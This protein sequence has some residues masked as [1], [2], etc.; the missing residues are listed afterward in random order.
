MFEKIG[1]IRFEMM[2]LRVEVGDA[3]YY[4]S[5]ADVEKVGREEVPLKGINGDTIYAAGI[6]WP[7]KSG[8]ALN[9]KVNG[10]IFVSPMRAIIRLISG[11]VRAAPL[12]YPLDDAPATRRYSTEMTKGLEAGF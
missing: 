12:S 6:A 10:G 3:T 2:A 8:K 7:S 1:R 9:V 5:A 4:V 11:Q